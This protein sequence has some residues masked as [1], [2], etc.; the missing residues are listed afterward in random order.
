M[1]KFGVIAE[2]S[3]EKRMPVPSDKEMYIG[4]EHLDTEDLEV[5]RFGSDVDITGQKLVMQKGDLLFG[6]RNT[7]LRRAAIA[8]HDGLFSAHGMILRPNAK[9]VDPSFFP[10]FILSDYFM[11]AAIRISVG[12]LSPTVNWSTLKE[13]EFSLPPLAEQKKLAETL[14]AMER[15]KRAYKKLLAETDRLVEARFIEMFGDQQ[16]ND[17]GWPIRTVGSVARVITG[18][19]PPRA[20]EAN[21]GS[22][23][24]WIKT[25]N[26]ER[27]GRLSRA[28]ESLSE[29]GFGICR[30]VE[31][32]NLLMT[33]IA[34]SLNTIG[35]TAITDRRVAF[36]QQINALVPIDCEVHF[37]QHALA[38]QKGQIYNKTQKS[39]KCLLN[40]S[41]LQSI[42]ILLPPLPLQREFAAFVEQAEKAKASLKESLAALTAAQ[43][44]LMNDVFKTK[45][46]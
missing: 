37:L 30:Y 17:K 42:E 21:F 19:T 35:N 6:R 15:V 11:N 3:K 10:F 39:L 24:E 22:Y 7:Y 32:N 14:W 43:K 4:L 12:S 8:P 27:S 26:I 25:N 28:E 31:E 16:R 45:H 40:K 2:S 41:S 46:V 36:N 44:S 33:C 34:G 29:Q 38:F 9:V 1:I 18:N 20:D 13:L 5:H 23:I